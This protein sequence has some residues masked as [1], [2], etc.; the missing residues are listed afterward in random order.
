MSQ[1][2]YA[3]DKKKKK[4]LSEDPA[5]SHT[6][7]SVEAALEQ[8]F[9][10]NARW[11]PQ[12]PA[13]DAKAALAYL[14]RLHTDP[15]AR[16]KPDAAGLDAL[17]GFGA[18]TLRPGPAYSLL[19]HWGGP[20]WLLGLALRG[21]LHTLTWRPSRRVFIGLFVV[22]LLGYGLVTWTYYWGAHFTTMDTGVFADLVAGLALRGEYH[23]GVLGV[24]GFADHFTPTLA[25]FAPLF[26]IEPTFLWLIAAKFASAL[27]SSVLLYAIGREVLGPTS[28]WLWVAPCLCL[29]HTVFGFAYLFQFQPTHLA[30]PLALASFLFA[31]RARWVALTLTL[32]VLFGLKEDQPLV[33]VCIGLFLILERHRRRLGAAVLLASIAI[34]LVIFLVVMP[35]FADGQP[36]LQHRRWSPLSAWPAKLVLTATL[37]A[38]VGF[39]PL[40][41]PRSLL[42][43][44][45]TLGAHYLSSESSMLDFRYHYQAVPTA[46]L[47]V[48]TIYGLAAVQG[49]TGP[50][51][52]F[53]PRVRALVAA[54]ALALILSLNG[55]LP[56]YSAR[57]KWPSATA[58]AVIAEVATMRL[59]DDV[60]VYA[61]DELLP[62]LL[63]HPDLRAFTRSSW[64]SRSKHGWRRDPN[65]VHR[66]H[67]FVTTTEPLEATVRPAF[68]ELQRFAGTYRVEQVTPHLRILWPP[69]DGVEP[70]RDRPTPA[71]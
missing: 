8:L 11:S 50:W 24:H 34:G 46:L 38:T 69:S 51:R 62:Y 4:A 52:R 59:P 63:P 66:P 9:P 26:H 28:R 45:P 2:V 71:P 49:D 54:G 16:V 33:G 30:P 56:H 1:A 42:W 70:P 19:F 39:L 20:E 29:V 12:P 55:M 61:P 43:I 21:Q 44:L 37:F 17:G 35:A 36:L 15:A 14:A 13:D 32:L 3:I 10:A 47:L 5:R 7:S 31:L 60:L 25:L 6:L 68:D 64:Y 27:T 53:G 57:L 65:D 58:R 18:W 67:L 22:S 23:S 41:H 40:L 48:A